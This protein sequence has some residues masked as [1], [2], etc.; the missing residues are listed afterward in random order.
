M[1]NCPLRAQKPRLAVADPKGVFIPPT[2]SLEDKG[3][4][5]SQRDF[6]GEVVICL[7][8]TIKNKPCKLEVVKSGCLFCKY[9]MG[10]DADAILRKAKHD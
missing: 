9:H 5:V 3:I 8:T 7:G 1:G 2:L 6:C 10:Q 4:Q